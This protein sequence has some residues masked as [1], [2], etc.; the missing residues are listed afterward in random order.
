MVVNSGMPVL[1][2][3][4]D[5]VAGHRLRLAAR[6]GDGR[7]AGRRPARPRRTGRPA[8]GH[9]ARPPRPTARCCTRSPRDGAA[10]RTPR[11][12]SSATGATTRA[13]SHRCSRSA[14]DSGYTELGLRVASTA[15]PGPGRRGRP[16]RSG[17]WSAT[18]GPGPAARSSRRMWPAR[19]RRAG[20]AGPGAGRVRR[21]DRGARGAGGGD[22]DRAGPGV[23]PSTT[24]RPA[25][26]PGR[27]GRS[28]SRSAVPPATCGW[29]SLSGLAADRR[30]P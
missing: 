3:W 20:A 24:G 7:G 10:R 26:G 29:R 21:G 6:P 15:G 17:S 1:M 25:A 22:A 16:Q 18:P 19:P 14:M 23:R 30:R 2:P 13:A 5:D 27:P 4:A 9:P 12:C 28:R 11:G 8:A